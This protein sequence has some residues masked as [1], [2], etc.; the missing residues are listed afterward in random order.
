MGEFASLGHNGRA[1]PTAEW[2]PHA[3]HTDDGMPSMQ[4][5]FTARKL[6]HFGDDGQTAVEYAL[7]LG[8]ICLLM[9]GV[10]AASAP[11]WMGTIVADIGEAMGQAL[12]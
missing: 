5:H 7:V 1:A 6:R 10:L 9:V 4:S 8:T 3:T 11:A 2:V 12:G